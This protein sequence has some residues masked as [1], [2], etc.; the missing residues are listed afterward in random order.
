M[1]SYACNKQLIHV[2]HKFNTIQPLSETP[3]ATN[4]KPKGY[5]KAKYGKY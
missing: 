4:Q 1:Y 2:S 5:R 3:N